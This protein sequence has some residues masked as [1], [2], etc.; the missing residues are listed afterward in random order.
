MAVTLVQHTSATAQ[1]TSGTSGTITATFG[2]NTA[3]GNCLVAAFSVGCDGTHFLVTVSSVKTGANAENWALAVSQTGDA[4][5]QAFIYVDP[6]TGGGATQVNVTIAFGA[7]ASTSESLCILV[8]VYEV[9]GIVAASPVDKTSSGHNLTSSWSSGATATTTNPIE[10][11]VG[12][13][14]NSPALA[15]TTQTL[16]GPSSPWT[17]ETSLVSSAQQGGTVAADK[18]FTYQLSGFQIR[19]ATGTATYNGTSTASSDWGAAVVTLKSAPV[20]AVFFDSVN[21]IRAKIPLT[22]SKGR[23]YQSVRTAVVNP[24]PGPVFVQATSPIRAR[25]P[26]L[27][28][29]AGRVFFHPGLPVQNPVPG[30]VHFPA[31]TEIRARIPQTFSKGRS[32]GNQGAPVRNATQG[33]VFRQAT[34][35][36]R[37]RQPL[38]IRGRI[39]YRNGGTVVPLIFGP[40]FTP[41]RQPVRI[42]V[43]LPPRGRVSSG[44]GAPLRNPTSGPVFRPFTSPVRTHFSLPVRGVTDSHPGG[45]VKNGPRPPNFVSDDTIVPLMATV[46]YSNV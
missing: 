14:A 6:S 4:F 13:C 3:V 5:A 27:Q 28:P 11:W 42:R 1:F 31:V 16:T 45:P 36:V 7:T 41:F 9:S 22:F 18:F 46:V 43:T 29:R 39:D 30:P 17:N 20:G 10:F 19:S 12:T 35:P 32:S 8:D 2:S 21:E 33:P 23:V 34:S 15:N 38:P 24:T 37:A 40:A 44:K 26:Q 25:L